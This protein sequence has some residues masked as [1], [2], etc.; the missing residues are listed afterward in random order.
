MVHELALQF[1]RQALAQRARE[2]SHAGPG[3]SGV[4]PQ[5]VHVVLEAVDRLFQ[6]HVL[7]LL[8]FQLP[9]SLSRDL[10]LL[11]HSMDGGF[12]DVFLADRSC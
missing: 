10:E 9:L 7:V 4:S 8:L 3:S 12:E 6:Q 2:T 11:S 1:V 5:E